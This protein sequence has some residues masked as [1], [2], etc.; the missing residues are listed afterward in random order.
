[1]LVVQSGAPRYRKAWWADKKMFLSFAGK[2]P[3]WVVNKLTKT[4]APK[5]RGSLPKQTDSELKS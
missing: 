5:V 2:L 1:M 4:F 3:A